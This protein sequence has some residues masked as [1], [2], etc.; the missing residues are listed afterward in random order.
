[1]PEI[2]DINLDQLEDYAAGREDV[3]IIFSLT[4]CL[5]C[6]VLHKAVERNGDTCPEM[7]FAR[8]ILTPPQAAAAFSEGILR[9]VPALALYRPGEPTQVLD[10]I[11]P[12]SQAAAWK[13]V[14]N[15]V[16]SKSSLEAPH[17]AG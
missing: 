14:K 8:C 1:M 5:P 9:S 15:F 16:A 17:E 2:L 11:A 6:S 10:G 7:E 3:C 13:I 12:L 4:G